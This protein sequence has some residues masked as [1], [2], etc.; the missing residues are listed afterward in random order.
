MGAADARQA[1]SALGFPEGGLAGDW[2]P[3]CPS[4]AA[5]HELCLAA[6]RENWMVTG[7]MGP[8]LITVAPQWAREQW[9]EPRGKACWS[10]ADLGWEPAW[11]EKRGPSRNHKLR[12][13]LM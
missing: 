13:L 10:A 3:P 7:K 5:P 6:L 1:P 4:P 12:L 2:L 8:C 11:T 9:R